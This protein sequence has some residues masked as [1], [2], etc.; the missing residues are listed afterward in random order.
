M[1]TFGIFPFRLLPFL[2]LS[3]RLFPFHLL[4][5]CLLSKMTLNFPVSPTQR[6]FS[7]YVF[8]CFSFFFFK[9]IYTSGLEKLTNAN[10]SISTV[11]D[12]LFPVELMEIADWKSMSEYMLHSNF[13]KTLTRVIGGNFGA[14][15]FILPLPYFL[16]IY[17]PFWIFYQQTNKNTS[18]FPQTNLGRFRQAHSSGSIQ[19][20]Q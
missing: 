17:L 1:Y 20:S 16:N 18:E 4:P 14:Y 9:F 10:W 8:L 5:L 6:K 2:L 15:T 13:G 12:R 19:F 7:Y 3:F 11:T